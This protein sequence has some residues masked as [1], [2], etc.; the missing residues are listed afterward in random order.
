M[1]KKLF[2]NEHDRVIAGVS[3]G[4]ADYMQV[5]VTI[6]RI[7]F[8]LSAM[9]LAGTGVIVYIAMWIIVPVNHD[10]SVRYKK[11]N[12]YYKKNQG[13]SMFNSANA[14]NN[15]YTSAE[16]TKWN[17]EN[18]DPNFKNTTDTDFSKLNKSNDTGRTIVGLVL[19][20]LGIYFLLSQFNIIPHWFNIFKIYKLWPLAIVAIGISLIFKNQ[21]KNEWDNFKKTTEETQ[22]EET[23]TP[24]EDAKIID[25]EEKKS[26]Q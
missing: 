20:I 6:I 3:S 21:N 22:K 4:L 10:P 14:F 16:Q 15:P 13:T 26:P 17:T 25:E 2:R 19:L 18:V 12:D 11:F 1:E 7:L 9:F 5:D 24:V 23:Q 8:V